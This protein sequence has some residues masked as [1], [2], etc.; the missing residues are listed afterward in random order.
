MPVAN[1]QITKTAE[2][3][4]EPVSYIYCTP[5]LAHMLTLLLLPNYLSAKDLYFHKMLLSRFC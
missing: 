2:V 1:E 5:C 3:A 4:P